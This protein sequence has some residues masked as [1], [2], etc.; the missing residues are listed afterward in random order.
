MSLASFE[1]Y[2]PEGT[3]YA[4]DQVSYSGNSTSFDYIDTP[5]FSLI[6]DKL[7]GGFSSFRVGVN[8]RVTLCEN[9]YCY[10]QSQYDLAV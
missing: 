8:T 6:G 9:S 5:Y 7:P 10:P 2:A 1:E 3:V 4:Y